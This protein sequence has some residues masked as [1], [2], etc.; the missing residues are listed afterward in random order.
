MIPKRR[1]LLAAGLAALTLPALVSAGFIEGSS[2]WTYLA[3]RPRQSH[4]AQVELFAVVAADMP[5][6]VLCAVYTNNLPNG[7]RG[8]VETV[9]T[10]ERAGGN[11]GSF[12]ELTP[13]RNNRA[14]PPCVNLS[15]GLGRGDLVSFRFDMSRFQ[16]LKRNRQDTFTA[17][18]AIYPDAASALTAL[19][20]RLTR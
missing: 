14:M 11:Q 5:E 6:A 10:V 16:R 8:R 13:V 3:E 9:I 18:G 15:Q 1:Q 4:P 2:Q 20:R 7:N 17:F 19:S 12:R